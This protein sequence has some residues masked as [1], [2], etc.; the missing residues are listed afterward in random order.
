MQIKA[1]LTKFVLFCDREERRGWLDELADNYLDADDFDYDGEALRLTAPVPVNSQFW[2]ACFW[3]KH[4]II[5]MTLEVS[6]E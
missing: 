3:P 2:D 5:N 1:T 6:Y 4:T